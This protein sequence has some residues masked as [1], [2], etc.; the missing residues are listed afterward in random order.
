MQKFK[1]IIKKYKLEDRAEEIA[2]YIT[3]KD[4]KHFSLDEFA[5]KFNLKKE[6]AEHIL[7]IIY[8]AVEAREKYLQ[9]LK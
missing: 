2:E 7:N 8:K 1:Q 4:K 3:Y 6:D 5:K 9:E